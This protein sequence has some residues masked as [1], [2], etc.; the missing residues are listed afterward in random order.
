MLGFGQQLA[1]LWRGRA[2]DGARGHHDDGRTWPLR[3]HVERQ[4]GRVQGLIDRCRVA[5]GR[6]MTE[7]VAPR[8]SDHWSPEEIRERW[9]EIVR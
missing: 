4:A 5:A 2:V 8:N 3:T 7:G 9:G 1:Q 6:S